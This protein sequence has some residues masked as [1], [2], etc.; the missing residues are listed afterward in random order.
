M[1]A[2]SA[3]AVEEFDETD[4]KVE[5]NATGGDAGFHVLFDAKA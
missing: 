3:I 5:I 2:G 1:V 4:V